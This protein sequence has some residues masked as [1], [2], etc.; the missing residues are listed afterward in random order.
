VRGCVLGTDATGGNG[1]YGIEIVGGSDNSIGGDGA[2]ERNVIAHNGG[3]GIAVLG[4][5]DRGNSMI[6]NAVFSNGALAID[7]GRDGSPDGS[8][9]NDS[10][11]EDEG[12]NRLAN[13][14]ELTGAQ[15]GDRTCVY[16]KHVALPNHRYRIELF[17]N[18]PEPA[19]RSDDA[20]EFLARVEI[21]TNGEGNADFA[22]VLNSIVVPVGWYIAATATDEEN[23]TSEVSS[24]VPVE[25]P[26]P[27]ADLDLSISA[28]PSS[29]AVGED[30]FVTLGV[31]NR[32]PH[33]AENVVVDTVL[34][35]GLSFV[36]GETS[37]GALRDDGYVASDRGSHVVVELGLMPV[38]QGATITILTRAM[39]GRVVRVAGAT[40]SSTVDPLPLDNNA[41]ATVSISEPPQD[42]Y[43]SDLRVAIT[44]APGV[45]AVGA[46]LIYSVGVTNG[47]PSTATCVVLELTI[48]DSANFLRAAANQGSVSESAG[49]VTV[50]LGTLD[51][52]AGATIAVT[53]LLQ[54]S[55]AA[56]ASAAGS[57]LEYDP[58]LSD[59]SAEIITAVLPARGPTFRV[60][61]NPLV[62]RVSFLAD[63]LL[64]THVWV[65]VFDLTGT[66]VFDS[67][68]VPNGYTW[69]GVNGDG[70]MLGNGVYVCRIT[71]ADAEGNIGQVSD[72]IK[73][74]IAR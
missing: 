19:V 63:A 37:T 56:V 49:I 36:S 33:E 10:L 42:V 34:P 39:S 28:E 38:G 22:V 18:A 25:A 43:V 72:V 59:N 55:G 64:A 2:E 21:L 14:P 53:V 15:T 51:P 3:A 60:V 66:V 6:G 20:Q 32:G 50:T 67:G 62:D 69:T 44:A 29:V 41:A 73:L 11:D 4:N 71:S 31:I 74:C 61:P 47:G 58:D 17:A 5:G 16:G 52:G 68:W 46:P 57:A 35:W 12:P 23:N 54:E 48:P 13:K 1:W 30:V 9:S 8:T 24:G 7:L 65:N 70:I 27:M 26:M 45:A 40:S